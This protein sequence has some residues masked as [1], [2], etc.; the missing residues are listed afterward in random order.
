[1]IERATKPTGDESRTPTASA[2][3]VRSSR[4]RRPTM[5]IGGAPAMKWAVGKTSWF[6][7]L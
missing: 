1:M 2:L 7:P 4:D 5:G 6:H 3:R